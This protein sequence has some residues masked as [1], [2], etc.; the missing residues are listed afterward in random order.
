MIYYRT[1]SFCRTV[2]ISLAGLSSLSHNF[3][4]GLPFMAPPPPAGLSSPLPCSL[5]HYTGLSALLPLLESLFS[6]RL[7]PLDSWSY[8]SLLHFS[9]YWSVFL[10]KRLPLL[11]SVFHTASFAGR[12]SLLRCFLCCS[13]LVAVP[14]SLSAAI[15]T[16]D[17]VQVMPEEEQ[18]G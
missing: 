10:T 11:D 13:L 4:T 5:C 16:A 15:T 7:H 12:S 1:A 17:F 2:L 8:W 6:A 3:S 14:L 18:V 9:L